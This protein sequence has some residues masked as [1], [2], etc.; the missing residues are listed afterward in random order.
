[1]GLS[2]A[3]PVHKALR[4]RHDL[5]WEKDKKSLPGRMVDYMGMTISQGETYACW[6]WCGAQRGQA[7]Q[8][9]K[10]D[11]AKR[12]RGDKEWDHK[13]TLEELDPIEP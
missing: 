9:F 13:D 12:H 5:R 6:F 3:L 8:S 4:K 1:M 7:K 2:E 11:E 10:E